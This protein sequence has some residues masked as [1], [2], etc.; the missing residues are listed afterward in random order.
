MSS[1]VTASSRAS[2][3]MTPPSVSGFMSRRRNP[4]ATPSGAVISFQR[5][6]CVSRSDVIE[7]LALDRRRL[8]R[9][10]QH[11]GERR[12]V[13]V[14]LDERRDATEALYRLAIERPHPLAHGVVVRVE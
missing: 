8:A 7:D 13:I 10:G 9:L 3:A 12:D 5:S 11:L 4:S 14:P 6:A 1:R 2:P